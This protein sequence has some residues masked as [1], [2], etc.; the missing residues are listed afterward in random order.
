VF[1]GT[2]VVSI[3]ILR[4]TADT[5]TPMLVNLLGYWLIG[6]P[7]SAALGFGTGLGPRGLWWGLTVGLI[8]VALVLVWRVR[9]RLRGAVARVVIDH[10]TA[11]I[12]PDAASG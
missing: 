5:H 9:W 10:D 4:G 3:G 2:Q 11:P 7:I 12:A 8:L 6:L 1:D